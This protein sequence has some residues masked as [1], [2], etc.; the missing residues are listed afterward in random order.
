MIVYV[1]MHSSYKCNMLGYIPFSISVYGFFRRA[2]AA[3]ENFFLG[4]QGFWPMYRGKLEPRRGIRQGF[5]QP[6]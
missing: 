1:S 2:S 5:P 3:S 4:A 6:I